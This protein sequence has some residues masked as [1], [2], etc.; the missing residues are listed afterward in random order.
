[1]TIDLNVQLKLIFCRNHPLAYREGIVLM[2]DWIF[3][4]SS[5]RLWNFGIPFF[6]RHKK[7]SWCC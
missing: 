3:P 1:V 7:N 4:S 5:Y 2:T 6:I